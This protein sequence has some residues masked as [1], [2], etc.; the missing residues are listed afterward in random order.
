MDEPRIHSPRAT[1]PS[2]GRDT[3]RRHLRSSSQSPSRQRRRGD[4]LLAR[5]TPASAVEALRAPTGALKLCME[6]ASASE[7]SFAHRTAIA[8]QKIHGWVYE[9]SHWLWPTEGGS[10]GFETPP[11]KRRKL[12]QPEISSNNHKGKLA[13]II[14]Y[15]GSLSADDVALYEKRVEEIQED[16]EA[17]GLEEIK[18]HVL[19]NHIIPLS[20]PGTPFSDA[21]TMSWTKMEDLTAVVTAITVQAL[22]KLARLSRLLNVWSI[23]LLVLRKVP[24]L[25]TILTDAEVALRS[26][27]NAIQ[28]TMHK[29]EGSSGAEKAAGNDKVPTVTRKDFEVMKLVLQQKITKVGHEIDSMLDVLEGMEDTL[30]KDWLER[31]EILERDYAQWEITAE[32]QVQKDEL[33]KA[34][35]TGSQNV[36]TQPQTPPKIRVHGPKSETGSSGASDRDLSTSSLAR[37]AN[38][39]VIASHN[40]LA[41]QLAERSEYGAVKILV[42]EPNG[43]LGRSGSKMIDLTELAAHQRDIDSGVVVKNPSLDYDGT[44]G[45]RPVMTIMDNEDL[46]DSDLELPQPSSRAGPYNGTSDVHAD[47]DAKSNPILSELDRNVV[48]GSPVKKS[49]K[50]M[51]VSASRK[52][53]SHQELEHSVLE[54]V[55]EEVEE[56][57]D[58][59]E[60]PPARLGLRKSSH[61]SMVS[62]VLRSS[63]GRFFDR[64]D[65][66][67]SIDLELPR[68]PDPDDPFSSDAFSPP[69]SPPLRYR[70]STT[71]I[72]FKDQPEVIPLPEEGTTRPRGLLD[73]PEIFDPDVSF[74]IESQHSSPGRPS[75][76]NEE[77]RRL[78]RQIGEILQSVPLKIRLNNKA[79]A[80]NLNPP[81]FQLPTRSRA[82][83][84]DNSRGSTSSVSSRAGTPSTL[85]RSATPSYMLA[86]A[87]SQGSRP[88]SSSQEIKVYHLQRSTGE[89]PIKLFIRAVGEHG[90]RVMVRVGGGW[91]DLGE[92]LRDY[93]THHIRKSRGEGKV[94]VTDL[95]TVAHGHAGSS[96]LERPSSASDNPVSPLSIRKTRR[97]QGEDSLPRFPK[98]PLPFAKK[99][100]VDTPNY[101]PNSEI[102]V[103]SRASSKADWDEETSALGL[104]GPKPKKVEMSEESRAWIESVKEKVRIASSD[105]TISDPSKFGEMGKV[106]GTKRL[107]RK[108]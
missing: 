28:P 81:D 100:G 43:D 84:T 50:L 103:R 102:S 4:D 40:R 15:Y 22:P 52:L 5:L 69:S 66:E 58:E 73:P 30:P 33:S 60:L 85:S 23:R 64:S 82:K 91:S 41:E 90:E 3:F 8:S 25:L 55:D 75:T 68:L 86:P 48:R 20:R 38:N 83:T 87:R 57:E 49:L 45:G 32:Q 65:E 77:D 36:A 17:L 21:S 24:S 9:L 12:L 101:T 47:A 62:T 98:T 96:P 99:P 106:G 18:S 67:G 35:A 11:A 97:S 61:M 80:I 79:S 29:S 2:D 39:R 27:W 7:R 89:P 59:Q 26:G 1:P 74:E 104:A 56:E 42:D 71:S 14:L 93:A 16:M 19:R 31:L 44:Q 34:Y 94:E 88:K 95:P 13:D 6:Q 92:Y 70:R 63:P 53:S 108:N 10:A 37:D 46:S 51:D 78:Q 72:S 76:A 105:R 107:Y 54:A